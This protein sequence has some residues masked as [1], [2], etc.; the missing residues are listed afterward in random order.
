MKLIKSY[1]NLYNLKLEKK[2][3]SKK[4]KIFR[5]KLRK[6]SKHK[7][8]VNNGEFKHTNDI[9]N[10]TVFFYNRQLS[11]YMYKISRRFNK[12]FKKNVFKRKL[13]LI[14]KKGLKYIKEQIRQKN[15]IFKALAL[16]YNYNLEQKIYYDK[17]IKEYQNRY[18]KRFIKKSLRRILLFIYF[19]QLIYIN[20]SK[21]NSSYLQGLT[22]LVQKI[23]NKNIQFNFINVKYFYVNSDILTQSLVLKLRKNRRK[24]LKYLKYCISKTKI[25]NIEIN[26]SSNYTFN[27]NDLNLNN[28]NLDVTN[29]LLYN[30]FLE[31]KTKSKYLKNIILNN[32][33][34]KRVSGVR[35]QTAGRLTKRYTAS[36]SISKLRY[37]GNL[38]NINSSING[39]PSALLR[40]KLRPNLEFTKLNSKTR[41]G[42]F[43]IK[44]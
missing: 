29:K 25:K 8:F 18:Y 34:Y 38:I 13:L 2:N 15:I 35:I 27:T 36:R 26:S 31:N 32:I 42:S 16:K 10:I 43:G 40:G 21:F 28:S 30:L 41:I 7:I 14:R 4:K 11:N 22:E 24:L 44:G 3:K 23:Y 39:R 20:K 17:I 37:K 9:V 12:L 33:R 1:F 19:K 6:I 5:I